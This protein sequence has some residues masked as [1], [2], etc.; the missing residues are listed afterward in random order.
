MPPAKSCT[1]HITGQLHQ[2]VYWQYGSGGN[3]PGHQG[4][5]QYA[6]AH[7]DGTGKTGGQKGNRDE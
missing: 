7:A 1:G 3:K 4:N 2:S 5:Q 6:A